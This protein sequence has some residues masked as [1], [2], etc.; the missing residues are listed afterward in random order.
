MSSKAETGT[1]MSSASSASSTSK[2]RAASWVWSWGSPTAIRLVL[3]LAPECACSLRGFN[4]LAL[5]VGERT[6]LE[7]WNRRLGRMAIDH[8]KILK[9]QAG[10]LM[11]AVDPDGMLVQLH[12]MEHPTSDEA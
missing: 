3:H 12:T 4:I 7:H 5:G 6:D 1:W 11:E 8:S 2:K 9:G 10:W